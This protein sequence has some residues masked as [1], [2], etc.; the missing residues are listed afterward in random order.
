MLRPL[1]PPSSRA[2]CAGRRYF[3]AQPRAICVDVIVAQCGDDGVGGGVVAQNDHP[4]EHLPQRT[5][6]LRYSGS[7]TRVSSRKS[8]GAMEMCAS[9][10]SFPAMTSSSAQKSSATLMVEADTTRVSAR[11][12]ATTSPVVRSTACRA[13]FR[14]K[15][16]EDGREFCLQSSVV[17]RLRLP[18]THRA[19]RRVQFADAAHRQGMG[20]MLWPQAK[21]QMAGF[22]AGAMSWRKIS[23]K[24]AC[25]PGFPVRSPSS[26]RGWMP[27]QSSNLPPLRSCVRHAV[28]AIGLFVHVFEEEDLPARVDLPRRAHEAASKER[29]PPHSAPCAVPGTRCSGRV[30]FRGFQ[31]PAKAAEKRFFNASRGKG[32]HFP[33]LWRA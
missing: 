19:R 1:G 25:S 22:P 15:G 2:S 6:V 13:L 8:S 9:S 31:R 30:A 23:S 32:I 24:G 4:V 5:A 11:S 20:C 27:A 29:L 28:E 14:R 33:V 21:P 10:A 12:E 17:H 7:N 26:G 3:Q 18:D 16:V